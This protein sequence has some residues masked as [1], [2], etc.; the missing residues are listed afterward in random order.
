MGKATL[1]GLMHHRQRTSFAASDSKA[2]LV[3]QWIS[4]AQCAN[5]VC[6]KHCTILMQFFHRFR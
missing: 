6:L 4:F 2:A 5:W 3:V 1:S